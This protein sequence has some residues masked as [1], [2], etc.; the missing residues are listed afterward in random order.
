MLQV[1]AGARQNQVRAIKQS[2]WDLSNG[3]PVIG[4][5]LAENLEHFNA[6]PGEIQS[7]QP[8]DQLLAQQRFRLCFWQVANEE[9]NYRRYLDI[10]GLIALRKE[11]RAVFEATHALIFQLA[12]ANIV[13]GVRI[14]HIDDFADPAGYLHRLRRHLGNKAYVLVEKILAPE[15]SLYSM[16]YALHQ[17]PM[18]RLSWPCL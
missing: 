4:R 9:I 18:L 16:L 15:E 5:L 8:L 11:D 17:R 13:T 7:L 6:E 3:N 2:L 14:D 10:N 1:D 12:D